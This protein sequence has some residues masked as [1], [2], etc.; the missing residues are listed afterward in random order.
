MS[1]IVLVIEDNPSNM[2]LAVLL[3]TSE[4]CGV[5]EAMDAESGLEMART[6]RPDMILLDMRLPGMSGLDAAR[7]LKSDPQTADIPL[8]ALT[9]QAM[10]GN[11][12]QILGAGCDG[13][14]AKP[15]RRDQFRITLQRFLGTASLMGSVGQEE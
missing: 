6:A 15:V 11:E 13:Y 2:K 3:L 8:V 10:A 5:L 12:E 7:I 1:K 14:L 9:A 4:G